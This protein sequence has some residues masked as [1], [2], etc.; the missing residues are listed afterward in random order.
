MVIFM[1]NT[2]IYKFVIAILSIIAGIAAGALFFTE[3]LA[4]IITVIPYF[5]V[6]AAVVLAVMI[7]LL[8]LPSNKKKPLAK[9]LCEYS[10]II[11]FSSIS[12][13]VLVLL[14]LSV[15]SIAPGFLNAILIGTSVAAVAGVLSGL[16]FFIFCLINKKCCY[17]NSNNCNCCCCCYNN[18]S[19]NN[20]ITDTCGFDLE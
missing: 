9:C 3:R 4:N 7:V 18:N 14:I 1:C 15:T 2:N 20:N 6:I 16:F 12:T 5:A 19:N 11:V 17:T 13:I 8:L 10:G